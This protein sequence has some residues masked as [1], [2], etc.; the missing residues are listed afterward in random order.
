MNTR[1]IRGKNGKQDKPDMRKL[2]VELGKLKKILENRNVPLSARQ[3]AVDR[4][5]RINRDTDPAR[6]VI[7]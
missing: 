7:W 3:K 6:D 4:M 2:A 1:E 5:R